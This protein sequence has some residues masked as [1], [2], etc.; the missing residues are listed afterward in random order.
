MQVLLEHTVQ[1]WQEGKAYVAHAHP[2][3][4][5]S[6]GDTPDEARRNL[7]EAVRLFVK[8][9]AEQGTLDEVLREAGYT[10]EDHRWIAPA[11]LSSERT[12]VLLSA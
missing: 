12:S 10:L 6:C 7:D 3:D 11:L 4:V 1:V 8:V 5:M 9:A 2:L